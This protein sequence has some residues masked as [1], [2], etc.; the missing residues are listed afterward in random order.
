MGNLEDKINKI[1]K[2]TDSLDTSQ[3]VEGAVEG[4]KRV[5]PDKEHFDALMNL[6][7]QR[8]Q[9]V[10]RTE[11]T[12]K[13]SLMDQIRDINHKVDTVSRASPQQIVA[14]SQEVIQKIE[15]VKT[16]LATPNLELKG[17]VQTLLKNKLAHIDESLKVALNRA[18]VEYKPHDITNQKTPPFSP[19]ERFIG[20]LTH[21]QAELQKLATEVQTLGSNKEGFSPANMLAVQVK[22]NFIQQE[23][24]FFTNVLN[25]SL[26]SIKT[27]M[28]VQI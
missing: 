12:D 22:V 2:I 3:K 26:E 10:V 11:P 19:I 8:T 13:T 5:S 7:K 23:I 17:S 1:E 9:T 14:Q 6:D 20:F 18:G 21:G 28:N 4:T 25:K 27:I 16:K 15:E 24:E